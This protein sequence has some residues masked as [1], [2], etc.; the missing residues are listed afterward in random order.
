MIIR[1]A[2]ISD[3]KQIQV[4]RNSVTENTLSNPNLV[5]DEDCKEFLTVRGNG[6]VCEINNEVVGFS[7]V[8]MKDNNIWAL[9]V[10]PEFEKKGIGKQLHESMLDWYFEQTKNT[11]WLGTSPTTRAEKFYRKAGWVE[12]GTHGKNEIK[13]EMTYKDWISKKEYQ[14]SINT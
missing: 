6:W 12:V 9:F 11:V 1:E 3:I 8:D 10:N 5:T 4:V 7:I 2:R 13:F 14:S